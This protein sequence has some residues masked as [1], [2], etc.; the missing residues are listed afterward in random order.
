ML[1]GTIP[2][3][4]W[5]RLAC[6][7]QRD[8][9]GRRWQYHFDR[10]EANR[11]CRFIERLPHIKGQW[12]GT[13]IALEDWQCFLL[14]TVFGWRDAR[15]RRRFKVAYSEI[16][17]KNSKSTM[18]SGIGLYLMAADDEGGAEVYSAATTYDQAKIVWADAKQMVDRSP[19]FREA[20]GVKTTAYSI[21]AP[22]TAS[23][24]KALA[25]DQ[26]GN[27]DGLNVHCGII[28]E[29]HAH[30][31]RGVWDVIETATGARTQPLIWAITTAG[32]NRAGICYEQRTYVTKILDGVAK[33]EE[34]FGIIY[35]LDEGDD[36][37][38]PEVWRKANPNWGVSVDPGDI[39]RKARKAKEMASAQNNFL[40]KHLNVWVNADVAW[41]NMQ[42]WERCADP[43]LTEDI[44]EGDE[45]IAAC[46]LATKVDLAATMRLHWRDIDGE[47]HY[48]AFGRY[49]LPEQAVEDGRNSQYSGWQRTGRLVVTPGEVTDFEYIEED[50]RDATSRFRLLEVA[51]D[52]WQAQH[53]EQR[54]MAEGMKVVEHRQ[55]VQNMSEAMKELEALVLSRRF[56][57]DGDPVLTWCVSNV[58]GHVDVKDNIYP[59]KERYENKIDP[60]VALIM[61]LDRALRHQ[62]KAP[63]A[64]LGTDGWTRS[65]TLPAP[66]RGRELRERFT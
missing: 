47:R 28:D 53:L 20:L 30:K 5:V 16:P 38:D 18:S 4:K 57:F 65:E 21:Y 19:A 56:H 40:T 35:T 54:L 37:T 9:L 43:T 7:R 41:M 63:V 64:F 23:T 12:A 61:A 33:D 42:A 51:I 36:W 49:Y 58:V 55:I 15:G 39:A 29:L 60:A 11:V 22:H 6:Q 13:T 17:R 2:A 34:Y 10:E 1:D 31:D 66:E 8:D 3:C 45:C 44:F 48:Y 59:R 52:P 14:T 24:F 27:L 46:D 32:F 62:R 26:R 50:L 25:R